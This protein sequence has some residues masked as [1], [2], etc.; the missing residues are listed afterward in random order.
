MV[1]W[2]GVGG[3]EDRILAVWWPEERGTI[4]F[5][6]ASSLEFKMILMLLIVNTLFAHSKDTVDSSFKIR[7]LL[8]FAYCV[9]NVVLWVNVVT[10]FS[11]WLRQLI[12]K[13]KIPY[14]Q[15]FT[16][17]EILVK[18]S[19]PVFACQLFFVEYYTVGWRN[20]ERVLDLWQGQKYFSSL[21][22]S[23]WLRPLQI[24]VLVSTR[25]PYLGV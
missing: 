15:S 23:N 13:W 21:L 22:H 8:I 1:V 7:R 16:L 14:W 24:P 17:T 19:F 5:H 10:L 20:E 11:W 4:L 2:R 6:F 3:G 18:V 9:K 12:W 25:S